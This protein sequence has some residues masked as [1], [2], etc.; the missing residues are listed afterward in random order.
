MAFSIAGIDEAGYGPTLGPLVVS[1]AAFRPPCASRTAFTSPEALWRDLAPAVV[2]ADGG[3][4]GVVVDDSKRLYQAGGGLRRLEEGV[5]PFL[6]VVTGEMP[7]SFDDLLRGV[8]AEADAA[9]DET[10]WYGNREVPLPVA[11]SPERIARLAEGLEERLARLDFEVRIVT[12]PV[13]EHRL[14]RGIIETGSKATALF[15]EILILLGRHRDGDGQ[16]WGGE[17]LEVRVD[18]LGGRLYYAALLRRAFPGA[19]VRI[20][21]EGRGGSEYEVRGLFERMKFRFQEKAD[22][23]EL[24]VALAS[25]VSKYVRELF[26]L[27]F[28]RFWGGDDASLRPTAGYPADARR[29]LRDIREKAASLGIREEELVRIR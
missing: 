5:L 18:R 16:A 3:G 25:M 20:V 21:G 9:F 17:D 8:S 26:M 28:N 24:P 4:H 14:N 29:F 12:H 11:A 22:R 15:E 1:L 19:E 13:H 7:R 23:S 27:T 10:P 2:R 6:R